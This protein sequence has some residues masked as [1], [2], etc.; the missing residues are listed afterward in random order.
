[1]SRPTKLTKEMINEVC[2]VIE[3]GGS[4][5]DACAICCINPSTFYLWTSKAEND[6]MCGKNS[7]YVEFSNELKKAESKYK[8][9]H[10]NVI[11][12]AA[13]KGDTWQASAWLLERKFPKEF[14]R[15]DRIAVAK[16][17]DNGM[18]KDILSAVQNMGINNK[19]TDNDSNQ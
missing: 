4:N 11:N 18:M 2:K 16:E 17:E 3:N 14:A 9:V 13:L 19:N 15:T 7:I 1:M 12:K 5:A 8:I 6:R 10:L